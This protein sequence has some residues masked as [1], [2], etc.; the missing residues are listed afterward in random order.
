MGCWPDGSENE[1]LPVVEANAGRADQVPGMDGENHLRHTKFVPLRDDKP[2]RGSAGIA[3]RSPKR[4][5]IRW[6]KV[7]KLTPA[8][9]K[10]LMRRGLRFLIDPEPERADKDRMIAFFVHSCALCSA[11]YPYTANL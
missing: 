8:Q 9:V 2:A 3:A 4:R 10:N 7:V 11:K 6:E 5:N 1:G